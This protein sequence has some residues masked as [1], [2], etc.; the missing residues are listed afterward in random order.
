M[1]EAVVRK[2]PALSGDDEDGLPD[3]S[4]VL[5]AQLVWF[6]DVGGSV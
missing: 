6:C 2:Q 1:S 5:L 4:F 3:F